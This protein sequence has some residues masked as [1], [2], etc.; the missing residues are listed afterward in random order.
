[1]V[2][3]IIR[4]MPKAS[5]SG[6]SATTSPAASSS[7]SVTM[8]PLPPAALPLLNRHEA[9]VFGIH[10]GHEQRHIGIHAV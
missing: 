3:T 4:R 7:G 10:F 5:Y 9:Q 1:M 6:L 2:V 8:N